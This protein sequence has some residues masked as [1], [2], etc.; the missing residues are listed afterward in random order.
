MPNT[1]SRLD[2]MLPMSEVCTMRVLPWTSAMTATIS[3][4]ALLYGLEI[5]AVE[6]YNG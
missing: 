5:G 1:R 4:T 3:S 6:G 2:K